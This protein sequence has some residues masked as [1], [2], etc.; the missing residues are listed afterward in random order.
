MPLLGGKNDEFCE[1]ASTDNGIV[2]NCIVSKKID[3]CFEDGSSIRFH[4]YFNISSYFHI[5]PVLFHLFFR[6]CYVFS[7]HM[8]EANSHLSPSPDG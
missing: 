8:V 4:S 6:D 3:K 1:I 5:F 7:Q 2:M